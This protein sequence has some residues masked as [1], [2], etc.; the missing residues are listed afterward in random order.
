MSHRWPGFKALSRRVCCGLCMWAF[1]AAVATARETPP[2]GVLSPVFNENWQVV[3]IGGSRVGYGR[4]TTE[5]QM[6]GDRQV[7]VTDSEMS[8]TITRFGVSV[9][10]KITTRSEETADGSL[11]QFSFELQNPPA[12]TTRTSGRV[13]EGRLLLETERAGKTQ[14]S[15]QIWPAEAKAPGFQD[16]QLRENPL[17]PGE[18]RTLKVFDPQF[19]KMST[20]TLKADAPAEVQLL[21]GETRKLLKVSVST[22]T[23]P[24]IVLQEY[25]DEKGEA[26]V[27][28]T[29][30]LGMT[31]Y[32]TT[33]DEALKSLTGEEVDLG[34]ATLVRTSALDRPQQTKRVVYRL[35][36]P[37]EDP[38]KLLAD[39]PAQQ[40]ESI[41]RNT[42]RV[43]VRA[44]V[45]PEK[46]VEGA[47]APP[48]EF[49]SP[50]GFIQSDDNL[51]RQCAAAAAGDETDPWQIA[52]RIEKWVY[53][54]IKKKDFSTLLA[55]AA[56]VAKDRSGDCT[57]HAVLLAAMA[58][59]KSIPSRV[60]VGLVYVTRE[61]SFG[62]HMWTEVL[63][64]GRWTPLDATLGQGGVAAEHI[65][66]T[67][68]SFSDDGDV[69]PLSTFLP[70]VSVLG[71]LKIEVEDVEYR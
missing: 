24:G 52:R 1:C 56:E 20:V 71:K 14:K 18:T 40:V 37:G 13:S 55:S 17:R 51:V 44:I 65:K 7:V 64:N 66:F 60:V 21:G 48:K 38:A 36:A 22:S 16:R 25:L 26:I 2:A 63:I 30:L 41:D 4:T 50:N 31:T 67:D 29:S 62:G 10:T 46:P 43:T 6:R 45:P 5:P 69:S 57:E 35:H 9:K 23:A 68:A 61:Q 32:Q 58:R 34:I 12:A 47:A 70:L 42:A 8:L 15:H 54:N 28:K 53:E 39:G 3:Y 33:R 19:G 27:T 49:L 11:L 59:A